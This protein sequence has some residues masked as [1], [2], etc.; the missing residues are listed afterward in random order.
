M[1]KLSYLLTLLAACVSSMALAQSRAVTG[2]VSDENGAPLSGVMISVQGAQIFAMTEADGRFSINA[3]ADAIL[4]FSLLGYTSRSAATQGVNVVNITMAPDA[5]F[6]DDVVVVGY[7]TQKKSHMTGSV[8]RVTSESISGRATPNLSSS[9]AGLIPGM[10]V[11]Q[12]S[13]APG[14]ENVSIVIRGVGSINGSTPLILVD[15][16]VADMSVINP[17]DVESV[18]VLKDAASAAIYGSRAANGVILVTTKKGARTKPTV[19]VSTLWAQEK[20]ITGLEFMSDM[21]TFMSFMNQRI[22]NQNPMATSMDY[23]EEVIAAWRAANA[24]PNGMY[25]DPD[26]GTQVPNRIAFPNTDW[27]QAMFKPAFYQRYNM[28]ITG[29]NEATRYMM[30]LSYQNNPG[31]LENTGLDRLNARINLESKISDFLTVGTQ[32]YATK[33]YKK[34]GSTSMTYLFQAYPGINPKIDGKYGASEEPGMASMNN[35]L[36][37]IASQGGMNE[38]TRL[39][40]SWYAIADIFKGFQIEGRFNYSLYDRQDEQYSR[41][42][43]KYRFRWGATEPVENVGNLAQAQSYRYSYQSMSYTAN[44]LARYNRTFGDHTIS[45]L[46]GYE[47]FLQSKKGF[48]LTKRGLL[49]WN[50]TDINSAGEYVSSGGNSK[51]TVGMLSYFGE[52][53]YSFKN[54]YLFGATLRHDGSSR[55][56]PGNQW[57]TFPSVSAGWRISEENFFEPA[58]GVV[59]ELKLKASWG[60]LGA[61]LGDS[62]NWH[63]YDWQSSYV[64]VNSVFNESVMNGV[65]M[66]RVPNFGMTWETNTTTNFGLEASMLRSRLNLGVEYFIG[67]TTDMLVTPPT[68]QSLGLSMGVPMIN[69]AS[70]RKHGVDIDLSWRDRIGEVN[71]SV[72]LNAGY[73]RN[74]IT[75]Y[76]GELVW[77]QDSDL[78]DIWGNPTWRYTNFSDVVG[79]SQ[80]LTVEGHRYNEWYLHTPYSGSG[81]YT[82]NGKVDPNGGPKDGMIR[83]KQDLEWVKAMIAEG[84]QFNNNTPVGSEGANRLW[85]GTMLVAD[86]NGDGKYGTNEDRKFIGKTNTPKWVFGLGMNFEWKGIDLSMQWSGRLGQ[87]SYINSTGVNNSSADNMVTAL[88]KD[89]LNL[90]YSFDAVKAHTDYDNYDPA[91]DPNANI[92]ARYPRFTKDGGSTPANNT[93]Y[94]YNS[95][96]MKLKTL[97][98]G[99]TL[100]KRWTDAIKMS[101]LRVYATGE[102]LLTIKSKNFPG[103]DPELASSLNVYPIARLISGGLT[104]TF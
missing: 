49:D 53:N 42:L 51:E 9:L 104:V 24:N 70:M 101:S 88:P 44:F 35:V 5:Q 34:P 76:K 90:F 67:V 41:D 45:A 98:I 11:T 17:D 91:T 86:N 93:Y 82:S 71:Y 19:S 18:T 79:G 96:Y 2:T 37:S 103:V 68:Y 89:A 3:P 94:L 72:S 43:P 23:P 10:R 39:N 97:T 47:Q 25:T 38:F 21:P 32:T 27:A 83:T 92:S 8:A 99:Y 16:F 69:E 56:A 26:F 95:S 15:G 14:G 80:E 58:R 84:Y 60:Q 48:S 30:S 52:V 55:Y 61:T 63:A 31:S 74:E 36:H 40:T 22:I 100:P 46:A 4:D 66:N 64:K 13:G 28:S 65:V 7:G 102:N 62:D 87:W 6:I 77:G 81:K 54:R 85:Y 12:G 57:G 75:K 1:R 73:S 29:G 59:N 20:A 50:V 33:E 78:K